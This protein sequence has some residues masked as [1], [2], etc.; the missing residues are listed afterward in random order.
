MLGADHHWVHSFVG[1]CAG[2]LTTEVEKD[3]SL[4]LLA[5]VLVIVP[6]SLLVGALVAL[7]RV[8]E[9]LTEGFGGIVRHCH[10]QRVPR[11]DSRAIDICLCL[12]EREGKA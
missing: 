12:A 4:V 5:E 1:G 2:P 10:F 8:I 11:L 6:V 3:G 9:N 7:V